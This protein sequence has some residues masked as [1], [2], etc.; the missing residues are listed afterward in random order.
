MERHPESWLETFDGKSA[1]GP[2]WKTVIGWAANS[3]CNLA[4]PIEPLALPE[5]PCSKSPIGSWE[6]EEIWATRDVRALLCSKTAIA[7]ALSEVWPNP[8]RAS[9]FS[10]SSSW[11]S[12]G[13]PGVRK[14]EPN[15][16]GDPRVWVLGGEASPF[17]M[18][19]KGVET[20]GTERLALNGFES[21]PPRRAAS[22]C[23]SRK[24]R[25][26]TWATKFG[27]A[28]FRLS[29]SAAKDDV[30]A[31]FGFVFSFGVPEP[32]FATGFKTIF[33]TGS[34]GIFASSASSSSGV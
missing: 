15:I 1:G 13:F 34:C 32:A 20:W 4:L 33:L 10:C 6:A 23:P 21:P 29:R 24:W 12:P 16:P 7:N 11:T 17:A 14:G 22:P 26:S 18:A 31:F 27:I 30:V 9:C 3:A 2:P 8:S 28:L 25:A 19:L 5:E